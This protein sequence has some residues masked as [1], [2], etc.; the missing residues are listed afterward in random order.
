MPGRLDGWNGK[1]K[2]AQTVGAGRWAPLGKEKFPIIST[3]ICGVRV[4]TPFLG[5]NHAAQQTDQDSG[6]LKSALL[7][8]FQC[9]IS[10]LADKYCK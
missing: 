8:D 9:T 4:C 7:I 3:L 6:D 2:K 10:H 1:K 5:Y